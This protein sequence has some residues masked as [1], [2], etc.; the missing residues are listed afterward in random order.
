MYA[1]MYACIVYP[2]A[3]MHIEVAS[4]WRVH[5]NV[6]VNAEVRSKRFWRCFAAASIKASE[7]NQAVLCSSLSL[8]MAL[9]APLQHL[10][11]VRARLAGHADTARASIR[12]NFGE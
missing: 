10:V 11:T 7:Q 4:V 2:R 9:I 1:F 8:R 6:S 12:F 5:V 3:Y